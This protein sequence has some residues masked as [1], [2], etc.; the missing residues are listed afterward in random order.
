MHEAIKNQMLAALATL[1]RSVEDCPGAEW[2]QSHG[3]APFSQAAFHA[4]FY[5]DYYLSA[6]E[7]AFKAQ[8]FHRDRPQV[9]GE[10]EEL[11]DQMAERRYTRHE[12]GEYLEFCRQKIGD[13][14]GNRPETSWLLPSGRWNMSFLE[15][16][17]Y[18]TRHLQHH[19]AQLGLRLQQLSGQA[20]PWVGSGWR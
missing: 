4:L 12:I 8:P 15:L 2:D 9:F 20:Q 5:L 19:A 7:A 14:C 3:D 10:Y 1:R 17:V 13:Y 11:R 18:N 16:A 6:D